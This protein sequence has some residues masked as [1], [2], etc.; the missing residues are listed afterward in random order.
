MTEHILYCIKCKEYTM[1][2]ECCGKPT[3][4]RK[5]AKW[6]PEDKYGSYRREAKKEMLKE[7][8]LL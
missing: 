7:E 5:P 6:S 3:S 1:K 8:G 2:E 4:E